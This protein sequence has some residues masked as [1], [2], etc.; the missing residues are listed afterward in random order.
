MLG[1]GMML[2]PDWKFFATST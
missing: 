1:V 2:Y